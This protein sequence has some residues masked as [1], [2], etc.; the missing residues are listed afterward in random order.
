[1][2]QAD[3]KEYIRQLNAYKLLQLVSPQEKGAEGNR[4]TAKEQFKLYL[5][6]AKFGKS[7]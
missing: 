4:R 5:S 3:Y 2:K 7:A 6:G 1:M